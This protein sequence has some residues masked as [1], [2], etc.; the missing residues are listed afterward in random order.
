MVVGIGLDLVDVARVRLLL[1]RK[2][3]RALRRL[4]TAD[5]AVYALARPDPAKHLAARLAAKEAGFKALAGTEHA[6]TIAWRELEV[7]S[8][9]GVPPVLQLHGAAARRAAELR[10]DRVLLTLTHTETTAA[11]VVILDS[12][13]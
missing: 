10:V 1:S 2:G 5:E 12:D 6:R 13:A 4:F 8:A 11:A 7:A 3:D 9:P